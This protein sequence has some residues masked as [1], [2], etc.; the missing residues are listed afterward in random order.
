MDIDELSKKIDE[1]HKE[2]KKSRERDNAINMGWISIGFALAIFS[3]Y[4]STSNLNHVW[5]ALFFFIMGILLINN[6]IPLKKE[7]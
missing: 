7:N 2:E 5:F 3:N 4:I 1:Y 6:V